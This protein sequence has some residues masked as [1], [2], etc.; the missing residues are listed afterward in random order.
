[1]ERRKTHTCLPGELYGFPVSEGS[2]CEILLGFPG[3]GVFLASAFVVF[4]VDLILDFLADNTLVKNSADLIV[5]VLVV[6]TVGM[7]R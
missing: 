3:W 7:G 4:P 6:I 1:M 5:F 2:L